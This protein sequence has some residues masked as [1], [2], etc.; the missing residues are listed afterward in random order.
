MIYAFTGLGGNGKTFTMVKM[1]HWYWKHGINIYTNTK[2]LYSKYSMEEQRKGTN[3]IDHPKDFTRIEKYVEIIRSNW[4]VRVRKK[5][6]RPKCRGKINYFD[7]IEEIQSAKDG[8]VLFDEGQVLFNSGAWKEISDEFKYKVSQERKHDL[9]F[10]TTTRRFRSILIDYR[11]EVHRWFYCK[12]IIAIKYGK[13]NKKKI[14]IGLYCRAEKDM[15]AIR[16]DLPDRDT[17][18]IKNRY[19]WIHRWSKRLYDTKYDIGFKPIKLIA[20]RIFDNKTN[21]WKKSFLILPKKMS[22]K[23]GLSAISTMSRTLYPMKSITSSKN[24]RSYA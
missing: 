9:D 15:E 23:D 3:I 24:T 1:A 22:L 5:E 17:P 21:L 8:I 11:Q 18:I 7:Q 6:Y 16:E 20:T 14:L 13:K 19:F 4:L 2:L 10:F 12:E